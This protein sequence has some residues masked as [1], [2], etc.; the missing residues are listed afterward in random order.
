VCLAP[1]FGGK[2]VPI[3]NE[4]DIAIP[5]LAKDADGFRIAHISDLHFR[6]WNHTL[7]T[8]QSWLLEYNYDILLATGDYSTLPS[9]WCHAAKMCRRFFGP[10]TPPYGTYAVL[11]NH[12]DPHLAD[13]PDLPFTLLRN[14]GMV[15]TV[16]DAGIAIVGIEQHV[17]SRGDIHL[18]L[19]DVPSDVPTVMLAHYPSTVYDLP[20]G[21]VQLLLAGHTHGGQIRLPWLECIW[22]NDRIP[23][24]M[25]RGT[26]TVDE[27][28]MHVS[29]GVG[30]S[31]PIW[32][33][34]R[35]PAELSI[36]TLR[37]PVIS[38]Q[39]PENAPPN[40]TDAKLCDEL[41]AHV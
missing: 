28:T 37:S 31:P 26:H 34:F 21:G 10:I 12:D 14:E 39:S 18:A 25:A 36:L 29:A 22:P 33:R 9:R 17:A 5:G 35:C 7:E 20:S 41:P 38:T 16:G 30:V 3:L 11:G 13:E 1:G 4:I 40:S 27:T 32:M 15:L 6:R 8:V 23:R 19:A 2:N 24:S